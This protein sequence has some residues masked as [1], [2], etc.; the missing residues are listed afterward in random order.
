MVWLETVCAK[1][2]TK[3]TLWPSHI[4][5][6]IFFWGIFVSG[7]KPIFDAAL[8]LFK[9]TERFV[10]V[11]Y[12]FFFSFPFPST[13][14]CFLFLFLFFGYDS[15]NPV[16]TPAAEYIFAEFGSR[17]SQSTH[18]NFFISPVSISL[19]CCLFLPPYCLLV[20]F[21]QHSMVV[22]CILPL[23]YI[24]IYFEEEGRS[25]GRG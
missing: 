19:H 13:L 7:Q 25:W 5:K 9:S 8:L 1:N 11:T 3:V 16:H 20:V 15:N 2:S 4:K 6:E 17:L 14:F 23:E 21:L 12:I 18:F 22:Q 24:S 10:V